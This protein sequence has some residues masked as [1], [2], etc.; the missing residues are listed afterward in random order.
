MSDEKHAVTREEFVTGYATRSGWT[1]EQLRACGRDAFPCGCG[2]E[3]CEGWQMVNAATYADERADWL[4]G[5]GPDPSR[6]ADPR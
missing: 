6:G 1:P 5:I 3:I 2:D 4:A